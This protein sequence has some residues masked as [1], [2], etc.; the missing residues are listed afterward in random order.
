MQRYA[1]RL[2][3]RK[4]GLVQLARQRC[5]GQF[6]GPRK[7]MPVTPWRHAAWTGGVCTPL[8]PAAR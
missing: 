5:I 3:I 8:P 2:I 6:R 4:A 7:H 1:G